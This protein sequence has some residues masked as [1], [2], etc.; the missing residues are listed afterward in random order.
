V[1]RKG[2]AKLHFERNGYA[3]SHRRGCCGVDDRAG[4]RAVAADPSVCLCHTTNNSLCI[5][6]RH[7][8]LLLVVQ[9][10]QP[11]YTGNM[12]PSYSAITP[13]EVPNRT[14]GQILR[15]ADSFNE[16]EAKLRI[17]AKGYLNV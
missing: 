17:E 3:N 4:V 10:Y 5:S 8:S 12:Y 7:Q 2:D 11:C 6:S 15:G 9:C 16:D 14:E 1:S 13:A